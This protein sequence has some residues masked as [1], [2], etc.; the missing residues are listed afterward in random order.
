M[1]VRMCVRECVRVRVRVRA[2]AMNLPI[3]TCT[4]IEFVRVRARRLQAAAAHNESPYAY[5]AE[6]PLCMRV[7]MPG[8]EYMYV[9]V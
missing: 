4:Y 9:Y 7:C 1:S 8:L 2:S 6:D 3:Y 5:A